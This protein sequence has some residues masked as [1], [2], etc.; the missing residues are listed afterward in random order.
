MLL[1]NYYILLFIK[2]IYKIPTALWNEIFNNIDNKYYSP[3]S[4]C[5]NQNNMPP[6]PNKTIQGCTWELNWYF[7]TV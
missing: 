3:H 7:Q 6:L 5:P 2:P 1:Y 4:V